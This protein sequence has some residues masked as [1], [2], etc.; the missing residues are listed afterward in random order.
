MKIAF[1]WMGRTCTVEAP[2]EVARELVRLLPGLAGGSP[3]SSPDVT[4]TLDGRVARVSPGSTARYDNVP[5]AVWAAELAVTRHL[6][7]QE[8]RH[9]HLHAAA[10]LGGH[11]EAVVAVGPSGSGK[12]TLAYAWYRLGRP[13]FGDDVVAMDGDGLLHPF[14][15]PLKVDAARLR[16]AGEAPE[17]TVA[18]DGEAPDVWVDPERRAGWAGGGAAAAVFAEIRF[19]PGSPVRTVPVPAGQGVRTL[20]DALHETGVTGSEAID[21]ILVAAERGSFFRLEYGDAREAALEL[22]RMVG[23]ERA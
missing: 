1:H 22:L 19:V 7:A 12:S 5:E 4:V 10:A 21:R 23:A 3:A 20:L 13:L 15:R 6:L 17:E 2:E 11:G 8:R 14:R 16:E 18:W 9:C